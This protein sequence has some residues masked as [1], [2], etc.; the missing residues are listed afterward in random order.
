MHLA[1]VDPQHRQQ[2]RGERQPVGDEQPTRTQRRDQCRGQCGSEDPRPGHDRGVQRDDVGDVVGFDEFDHE[3]AAGRVVERIDHAEHQR[4]TEHDREVD[5]TT[6]LE[7]AE[8]QCLHAERGLGDDGHRPLV[9]PVGHPACPHA[10]QQHRQELAEQRDADIG[11]L[12]GQPVDQDRHRGQL[13]PGADVADQ[14][15]DE[16]QPGIA[17]A[18]RAEHLRAGHQPHV[19]PAR[20]TS[21][22]NAARGGRSSRPRRSRRGRRRRSIHWSPARPDRS[23]PGR[24]RCTAG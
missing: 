24:C 8:Q 12:A 5:Q 22:V 19:Y 1:A 11:G 7:H 21:A 20:A 13:H 2:D 18:Q 15:S 6:Q 23:P 17:V 16:E 10:Q 3:A 14:Q 4:Q 9:D